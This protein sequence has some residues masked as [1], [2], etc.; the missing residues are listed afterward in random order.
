MPIKFSS[1]FNIYCSWKPYQWNNTRC[2]IIITQWQFRSRECAWRWSV[3]CKLWTTEVFFV[4]HQKAFFHIAMTSLLTV[5]PYFWS[6]YSGSKL[7]PNTDVY[8]LC[9]GQRFT[10]FGAKSP[11]S[12]FFQTSFKG[13][14]LWNTQSWILT[15]KRFIALPQ[16]RYTFKP[17]MC[18]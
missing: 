4:R 18:I 1:Y 17:I 8:M 7:P 10:V 13:P 15:P 5:S 11:S 3:F 16:C 14:K 9:W 6:Q 12:R 2:D